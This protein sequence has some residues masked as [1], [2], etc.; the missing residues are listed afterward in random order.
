VR[1]HAPDATLV[2]VEL[3]FGKT[4]IQATVRNNGEGFDRQDVRSYVRSGHLGLAGMYERARLFGGS[5]NIT[6][7]PNENTLVTLQLPCA[8][9]SVLDG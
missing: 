5:L 4:E 2:Q 8:W 7:D 9:D 1:K 6:S 3:G